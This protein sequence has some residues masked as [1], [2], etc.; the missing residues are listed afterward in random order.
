MI[1]DHSNLAKRRIA[2]LQP[3]KHERNGQGQD[4]QG[5]LELERRVFQRTRRLC[6]D[7]DRARGKED[8]Q[9]P[10]DQ[11]QKPRRDFF[12]RPTGPE[13]AD[14]TEVEHHHRTCHHRDRENVNRLHRRNDPAR[15]LDRLA[16]RRLVDPAADLVKRQSRLT[17]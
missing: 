6:H 13:H 4:Q 11:R 15:G 12:H 3:L 1:E 9:W 7:H 10:P 17:N 14:Q 5:H 8:K 16:Q 2:A